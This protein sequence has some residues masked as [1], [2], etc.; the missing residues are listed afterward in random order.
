MKRIRVWAGVSLLLALFGC[1]KNSD[2]EVQGGGVGTYSPIISG[3]SADHE[4][5]IRGGVN[6]LTVL[7]TNVNNYPVTYH[8]MAGAGSLAEST[9]AT[10]HWTAPDTVGSYPVTVSIESNDGKGA[11]FFKSTT[12]QIFVE[13][14][15]VRWTSTPDVQFD[16]SPTTAGGVVFA[17]IQDPATGESE[18]YSLPGAGL[19]ADQVTSTFLRA[20]SPTLSSDGTTVVFAG[21]RNFADSVML[22]IGPI[23]GCDSITGGRLT[24]QRN[25]PAHRI[26]TSP[27]F[28]KQ[29]NWLLYASDSLQGGSLPKLWAR[30]ITTPLPADQPIGGFPGGPYQVVT[31]PQETYW[32]PNWGPDIDHDGLPDSVVCQGIIFFNQLGQTSRGLFKFPSSNATDTGPWLA[33]TSA[34]EPDWSPDGQH[35]VFVRKN[36]AGDRDIWI[37]NAASSNPDDAVRVTHGAADDSHPRFSADGTQILFVSNRTDRYGLNGVYTTERRGTNIWS[38]SRFD[39]P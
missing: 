15:Y 2:K 22:W 32:T 26:S 3:I 8:W 23:A 39:K 10:V 5:A 36:L 21:R 30:Q 14:D 9:S 24:G 1:S 4:P 17:Q 33:D 38:V 31:S 27:R 37:I 13:N 7:I 25:S 35:I 29:S 18:I 28:S 12:F 34:T 6:A 11:Y 16:P 20:F 19:G